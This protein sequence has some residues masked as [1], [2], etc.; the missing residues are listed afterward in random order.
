MIKNTQSGDIPYMK[1]IPDLKQQIE[2]VIG[3]TLDEYEITMYEW[4]QS[5]ENLSG[6]DENK[7]SFI[8]SK[9]GE[10]ELD[11]AKKIIYILRFKYG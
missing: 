11:F 7:R 3:T 2:G 8:R 4:M 9:P 6:L 10:R 5:I 1:L